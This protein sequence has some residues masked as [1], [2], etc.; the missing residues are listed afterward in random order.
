L[1]QKK[2]QR[3]H[4]VIEASKKKLDTSDVESLQST[5]E[6]LGIKMLFNMK[7][8]LNTVPSA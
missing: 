7:E 8:N 3:L 2:V 1:I 5:V 6:N 4:E